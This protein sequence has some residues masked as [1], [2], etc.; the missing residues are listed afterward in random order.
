M[1]EF[2]NLVPTACRDLILALSNFGS[3]RHLLLHWSLH[4]AHASLTLQVAQAHVAALEHLG[5]FCELLQPI[6]TP[7]C[8]S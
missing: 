5:Y 2:A 8:R 7:L 4:C 1:Q 6:P 3:T